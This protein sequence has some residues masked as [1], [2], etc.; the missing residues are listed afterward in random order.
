MSRLTTQPTKD[1]AAAS[2]L[3]SADLIRM[4]FGCTKSQYTDKATCEINGGVWTDDIALTDFGND[5]A[6]DVDG[7][8]TATVFQS[9]SD[10]LD[11]DDVE[12]SLGMEL[13]TVNFTMN[14]ISGK[15]LQ[16]SQSIELLNRPVEVWRVLLDPN[17]LAIVGQPFKYFAGTV[18]SGGITKVENGE[19]SAVS[20]ECSNEYYNFEIVRGI[21]AN[22]S[23]H[24][25]FYPNDTGF[26][27]T[28]SVEKQIKW[29]GK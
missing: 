20:I 14:A 10:L 21:R 11:Y 26:K 16:L 29:G 3:V 18:V 8:G 1:A 27:N 6:Y 15:W 2:Q 5:I 12:E 17:T 7:Q 13:G 28:S 25:N 24:Q 19:G 4:S 23:D 22:E 9:S